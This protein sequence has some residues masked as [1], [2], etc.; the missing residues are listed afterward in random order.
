MSARKY[1]T[2]DRQLRALTILDGLIQNA[3]GRFQRTFLDEPL[4]ERLRL[5]PRDP[6]VDEAVKRKCNTLIRQ[7]ASYKGQ[8]GL[9]S[10][11][12]LARDLP[13]K[14][15]MKTSQSKV[16]AETERQAREDANP[17]GEDDDEEEPP[18]PPAEPV[19]AQKDQ[20]RR[21]SSVAHG[22]PS[23]SVPSPS[24][25]F[26]SSSAN[27]TASATISKKKTKRGK[28]KPFDLARETPQIMQSIASSSIASTNL[29]NALKFIN[30]EAGELPSSSRDV[31]A[32]FET[33]KM[34]RRQILRYIQLVESEQ[35]IGSLLTAN[36]ELV[37]ALMAW[38]IIEKGVEDD[39]DSEI[40]NEGL[41]EE[42][43][44]MGTQ[45]KGRMGIEG[46]M[47]HMSLG[48]GAAAAPVSESPPAKP[49]RPMPAPT[50]P[51]KVESEDESE[52][53]DDANDPFGDHA[54]IR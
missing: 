37:K 54:A 9:S 13:R 25:V 51:Q 5:I 15:P 2:A 44:G 35:W 30:R 29:L 23:T 46:H 14:T 40:E 28:R 41:G 11:A 1:G 27:K 8:P 33:C 32:R 7:W 21:K 36:D 16:L 6:L 22:S 12:N 49:P 20:H 3:D 34:L 38:E 18:S 10:L 52:A 45:G 4:L 39:S 24:P 42:L 19:P 26:F 47:R 17:F 53:E 48:G 50:R 43:G 31:M